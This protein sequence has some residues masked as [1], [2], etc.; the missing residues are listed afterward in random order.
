LGHDSWTALAMN[1][2]FPVMEMHRNF[3]ILDTRK[4]EGGHNPR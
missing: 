4:L 2:K 1:M 3:I